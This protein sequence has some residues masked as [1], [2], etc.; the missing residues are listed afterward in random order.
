MKVRA[1]Q[2]GYY[3][4]KRQKPGA[5]FEL[6]PLKNK[7]GSVTSAEQQFSSK[8]MEQVDPVE[9]KPHHSSSK[10]HKSHGRNKKVQEADQ[11][12]SETSDVI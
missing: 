2:V 8:W 4:H 11:S 3:G 1:T 12:E 10:S 6:A 7:D 5:V 9:A